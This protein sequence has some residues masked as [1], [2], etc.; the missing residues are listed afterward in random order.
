MGLAMV[1][2]SI[3]KLFII[4]EKFSS[5]M[6]LF[7]VHCVLLFFVFFFPLF[8]FFLEPGGCGCCV[9]SCTWGL[10]RIGLDVTVASVYGCVYLTF[11]FSQ[12][13]P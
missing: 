11:T 10:Y 3:V 12:I 6:V 13:L 5:C 4:R 7:S 1:L 2:A 8:G 9:P